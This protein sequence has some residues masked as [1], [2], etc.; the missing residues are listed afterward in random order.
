MGMGCKHSGSRTCCDCSHA[1]APDSSVSKTSI[2]DGAIVEPLLRHSAVDAS[3]G[4]KLM[5][6]LALELHAPH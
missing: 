4:C 5:A 3:Q 1:S 6:W 2:G